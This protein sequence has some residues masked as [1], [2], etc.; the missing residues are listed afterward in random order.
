M[1][2]ALYLVGGGA[3]RRSALAG[4]LAVRTSRDRRFAT[5]R[6]SPEGLPRAHSARSV[7]SASAPGV[8]FLRHHLSACR[9]QLCSQQKLLVRC[10]SRTASC[11]VLLP[12]FRGRERS[13]GALGTPGRARERPGRK[14]SG[15]PLL[16]VPTQALHSRDTREYIGLRERELREPELVW[17]SRL[18]PLSQLAADVSFDLPPPHL[19]PLPACS[20]TL[21]SASVPRLPAVHVPTAAPPPAAHELVNDTHL[22]LQIGRAHV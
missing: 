13:D 12:A 14:L 1:G 5:L 6:G 10:A 22:S 11:I 4:Q 9:E 17:R 19:L 21:P 20:Q 3:R 18:L 15:A 2:I 16:V 8:R 7:R